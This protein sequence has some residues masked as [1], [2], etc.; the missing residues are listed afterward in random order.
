M[1]PL[2]SPLSL[3]LAEIL[4]G[5]FYSPNPCFLTVH[6]LLSPSQQDSTQSVSPM[7]PTRRHY[8]QRVL[9]H[10]LHLLETQQ[11]FSLSN[12]KLFLSIHG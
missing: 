5:T 3:P 9:V 6:S 4:S 7:P 2:N 10:S 8:S 11:S 12:T 1:D